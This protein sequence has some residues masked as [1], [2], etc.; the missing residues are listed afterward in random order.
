[1]CAGMRQGFMTSVMGVLHMCDRGFDESMMG[2][3]WNAAGV[4][5]GVLCVCDI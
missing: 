1:M 3:C 4:H 5:D 2:V